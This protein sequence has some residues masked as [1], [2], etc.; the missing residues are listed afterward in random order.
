MKKIVDGF[1]ARIEA[2]HLV[3]RFQG[4]WNFYEWTPG[5]DGKNFWKDKGFEATK[6]Y[7]APLNAFISDA[8]RCFAQICHLL[9]NDELEEQYMLFHKQMNVAMHEAF[10]DEE[11]GAYLTTLGDDKPRHALTQGLMLF[12]DAV[13]EANVERVSGVIVKGNLIPA[14]ISMTI[15]VYDALLKQGDKYKE[16]VQA[17]IE[18][19][20]GRML[21]AGATTF[22]ETE[23]GADDFAFAGSLCHGWSAVPIYI[24]GRYFV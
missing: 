9:Q 16:Y 19:V 12:A 18:R 22:W 8:F 13:P 2:N 11:H 24:W 10:Y 7:D 3:A 14:S 17:E 15:Y 1:A 6:V 5:M 20:W 4:Y 23:A 21:E